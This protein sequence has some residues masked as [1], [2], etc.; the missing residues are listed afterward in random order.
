MEIINNHP[1]ISIGVTVLIVGLVWI[2]YE[3]WKAPTMP[4]DW[5]G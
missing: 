4:D 3:F 2:I 5:E 1:Y